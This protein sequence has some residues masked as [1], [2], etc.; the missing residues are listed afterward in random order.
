MIFIGEGGIGKMVFV[1]EVVYELFDS[2]ENFYE[3]IFWVLFKIEKLIV[4]GVEELRSVICGVDSM[5]CEL[6]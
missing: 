1:F 3:V 6:G 5:I 4:Y 2:D